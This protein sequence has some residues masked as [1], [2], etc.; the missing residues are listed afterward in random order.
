MN[1]IGEN[2]FTSLMAYPKDQIVGISSSA[3]AARYDGATEVAKPLMEAFLRKFQK[4]E[5]LDFPITTFQ[6][7]IYQT[8]GFSSLQ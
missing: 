7:T 3:S 2:L 1:G 8:C 4:I 6:G 5:V